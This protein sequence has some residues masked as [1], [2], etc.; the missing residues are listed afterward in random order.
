[1]EIIENEFVLKPMSENDVII[2]CKWLDKGYI[3]KWF[4]P[5][6]EAEREAWLNEVNNNNGKYD[7]LKHFIVYCGDT[8]IG[9]CFYMD[10]FFE[11]E[12]LQKIYGIKVDEQNTAYAI[13][14]MIGEEEYLNKGI[15]KIIVKKMEEKIIEINGKEIFADTDPS[16][17]SSIKTLLGNGFVKIKEGAYRKKL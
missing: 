14:F 11:Q 15:G 8:K 13:G 6:G 7:H 16:N 4:C 9:Y 1:M 17:L 5:N 10:I 12:Y 3:Y 2:F